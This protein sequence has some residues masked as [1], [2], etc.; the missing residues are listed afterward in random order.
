MHL[1]RQR[2]ETE[3]ALRLLRRCL[4]LDPQYK[5]AHHLMSWLIQAD[6]DDDQMSPERRG[7]AAAVKSGIIELP[8]Y[9]GNDKARSSMSDIINRLAELKERQNKANK[10]KTDAAALRAQ[11]QQLPTAAYWIRPAKTERSSSSS[12]SPFLKRLGAESTTG[13]QTD[14]TSNNFQWNKTAKN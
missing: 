4:E 5:E 1:H 12:M 10:S 2:N 11:Q 3:E 8:M 14:T 6:L 9:N 7:T 13:A